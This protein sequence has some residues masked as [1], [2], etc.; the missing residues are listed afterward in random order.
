MYFLPLSCIKLSTTMTLTPNLLLDE[1]NDFRD[2]NFGD[3]LVPFQ[4]RYALCFMMW[5]AI[6]DYNDKRERN[7]NGKK[8]IF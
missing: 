7:K 8:I 2:S 4:T 5:V 1:N 3:C 6:M